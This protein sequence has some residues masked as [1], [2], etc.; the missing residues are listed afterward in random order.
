M[1]DALHY[2]SSNRLNDISTSLFHPDLQVPLGLKMASIHDGHIH[3]S[4]VSPDEVVDAL[5]HLIVR[6][7]SRGELPCPCRRIAHDSA[8]PQGKLTVR[9]F[10]AVDKILDRFRN[11]LGV[12]IAARLKNT[13]PNSSMNNSN[14]ATGS[15]AM[16]GTS[17][18][19]TGMNSTGSTTS[20][21]MAK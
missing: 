5:R 4:R 10:I 6:R 20:G 11:V 14:S 7:L 15:N 1:F 21:G 2:R 3:Q 12:D 13:N 16:G 19:G 8:E 17:G 18:T 9:T